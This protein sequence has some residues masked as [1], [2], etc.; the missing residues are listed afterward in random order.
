MK[1]DL[2]AVLGVSIDADHNALRRAYRR[3]AKHAHP[4]VPGGSVKRFQLVKL[5]YD[6]LDDENRRRHYDETGEFDQTPADNAHSEAL[7][8]LAAAFEAALAQAA[9][10]GR[11]P[12]TMDLI[13]VMRGWINVHLTEGRKQAQ[14]MRDLIAQNET[15]VARFTGDVMPSIITGRTSILRA[16]LAGIEKNALT[17]LVALELLDGATF[18]HEKQ[19]QLPDQSPFAEMIGRMRF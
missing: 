8:C 3:A 18:R 17:G 11:K 9:S 14:A 6:T 12:E 15:L 1:V 7:Q 13:A 5:A 4:D 2:Y 10:S 19:P 16:R